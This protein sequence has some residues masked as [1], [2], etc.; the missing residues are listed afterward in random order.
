MTQTIFTAGDATSQASGYQGGNDGT[1]KMVVGPNGGK[2]D[3]LAIDATG[4]AT[5]AKPPTVLAPR[6]TVNVLGTR[7]LGSTIPNNYGNEMFVNYTNTTSSSGTS[8]ATVTTGGTTVTHKA[9]HGAG[10]WATLAFV[11]PEGSTYSISDSVGAGPTDL[12]VET[13]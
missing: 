6:V 10:A 3:A 5:L 4:R 2:I 12:W 11:V 7:T 13:R 1:M 8:T 9:F